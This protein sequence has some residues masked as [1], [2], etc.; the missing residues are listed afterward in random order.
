[1]RII[2][3]NPGDSVFSLSN[4][5]G[6]K[7]EEITAANA[8]ED[9]AKL[10]IGQALIIPDGRV[11][12]A[13]APGE[14]LYR[15]AQAYRVEL[16]MLR[17]A[18][19]E[20]GSGD[21]LQP[22]QLLRI[23]GA[24]R[25]LHPIDVNGYALEGI[26]PDI[27]ETTLENLTFLSFFSY[28]AAADGNL[29][30][31]EGDGAVVRRSLQYRAAPFMTVTNLGEDGNFDS[32]IA[33]AI[34]ASDAVQEHLLENIL[35][36]MKRV[37][38][39]GLN[40]DFE[41]IPPAQRDAYS[42]FLFKAAQRLHRHGYWLSV[43]L[44]PKQ[45]ADQPGLLYEA[46]DYSQAGQIADLAILMTY[47]WGYTY[48]PP[49]AVAPVRQVEAVLQY[50]VQAIP[51]EKILMGMPNYGYDWTLPHTPRTAAQSISNAAA[52]DLAASVGADIQFDET[53]QSPFFRYTDSNAKQHEVWFDDARSIAA[54]LSLV[55]AY[56]LA[57]VSYWNINA[58]YPQNWV[59][60]NSMYNVRKIL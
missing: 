23:P 19:P 56:A 34:L 13:V 12:H 10:L 25:P 42:N 26:D 32:S 3:V 54:R 16:P 45:S 28:Q 21:A 50:A 2:T 6:V 9:A 1:M 30:A 4:T 59:L 29:L 20:I 43:A 55:A 44:V 51:S 27:L 18:N 37:G 7:P 57:G 36:Q 60:L 53:A 24:L 22:G 31:P 49:Q 33:D 52:L 15:I 58:Y 41:Y 39:R 35:R 48:S 38:Y 8:L 47:E 5:Y 11:L 40:M 14:T 46:H 17:A